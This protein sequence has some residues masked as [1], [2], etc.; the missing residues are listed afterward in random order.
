MASNG[1]KLSANQIKAIAAL[2]KFPFIKDAA[3]ACGLGR[4]TIDRYLKQPHFKAE[5]RKQ[6][7]GLIVAASAALAGLAGDAIKTLGEIV[8]DEEASASVRVRAAIAILEQRRK[9]TEL[10]ELAERVQILEDLAR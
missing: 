10:D 2:L 4:R 7:D 1:K 5:L 8:K 3:Q 6:Q 9:T